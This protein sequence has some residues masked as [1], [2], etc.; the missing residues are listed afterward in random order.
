MQPREEVESIHRFAMFFR[1]WN[2]KNS[3]DTITSENRNYT[4]MKW[5][6]S[7][8]GNFSYPLPPSYIIVQF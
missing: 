8:R 2:T 1:F 7:P 4:P 5:K 3:S 6:F